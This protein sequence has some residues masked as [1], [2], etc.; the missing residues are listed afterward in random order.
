MLLLSFTKYN[1]RKKC[2][3]QIKATGIFD[4]QE[5]SFTAK[6]QNKPHPMR[7]KDP[8][9]F[10]LKSFMDGVTS[11]ENQGEFSMYMV[12]RKSRR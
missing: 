3:Y 6:E 11:L 9:A 5:N 2:K 12:H 10:E 1:S 7:V 8:D 4:W